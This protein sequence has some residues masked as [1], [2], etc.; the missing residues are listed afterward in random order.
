MLSCFLISKLCL[1]LVCLSV[2]SYTFDY[3]VLQGNCQTSTTFGNIRSDC[4]KE[5]RICGSIQAELLLVPRL[6]PELEVYK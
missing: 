1:V 2:L 4:G 3:V 5:K 6:K